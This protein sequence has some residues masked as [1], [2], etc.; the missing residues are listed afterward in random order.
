M[1]EQRSRR[2]VHVSRGIAAA[3]GAALLC[4][5]PP[6]RAD[7]LSVINGL[8]LDGCPTAVAAP[9]ERSSML[10]AAA[11]ELARDNNL[12]AAL[13]RVGYPTASSTSFHVRGAR[14][15]AVIRSMLA[16]RY[17]AA[18][19]DPKYQ[20]L[21][22][23]QSGDETWIVLAARAE[24]PFAELRDPAAVA[25]RV[26]ELV[27]T[28]R[29]VAR[30]CAREHFE[31][32]APLTAAITLEAAAAVHARDMADHRTL[33]HQGSDGSNSGDRMTRAGYTWRAS[34]E[35]IAAGQRDADA[36]V[37]GWLSSPGHCATLMAPYFTETGIAFALAPKENPPVYW[38]QEFA[39]PR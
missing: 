16:E 23:H 17:C 18:I 21:G 27:N 34:G 13:E 28:A 1:R 12:K 8:R 33:D 30:D 26:L 38:V 9:V 3:A 14:D 10:D 31:A 15:D 25:R 4:A 20:E 37:A 24:T 36:V 32:A 22:A 35:N 29:S 7:A 11:R 5:Q 6:A 2:F 39:A 19:G